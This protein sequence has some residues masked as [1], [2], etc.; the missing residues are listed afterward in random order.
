MPEGFSQQFNVQ[1]YIRY[2]EADCDCK[3]KDGNPHK[4][5]VDIL[6]NGQYVVPPTEG[7]TVIVPFSEAIVLSDFLL[8]FLQQKTAPKALTSTESTSKPVQKKL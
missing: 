4:C 1:R 2:L 6:I 3:G 5:G 8:E 7:Y